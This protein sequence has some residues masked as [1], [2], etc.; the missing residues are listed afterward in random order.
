MIGSVLRQPS[1]SGATIASGYC[2][3]FA[4]DRSARPSNHQ[5]PLALFSSLSSPP[6]FLLDIL[7][8]NDSLELSLSIPSPS[9]GADSLFLVSVFTKRTASFL[10]H[11][12]TVASR[13]REKQLGFCDFC[14]SE[15]S[16]TPRSPQRSAS[17]LFPSRSHSRLVSSGPWLTAESLLKPGFSKTIVDSIDCERSVGALVQSRFRGRRLGTET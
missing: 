9:P 4:F 15:P 13:A 3:V 6:H 5:Y 10:L 8:C 17:K 14:P 1:Q 7:S 11:K 2:T 16:Q 12:Q